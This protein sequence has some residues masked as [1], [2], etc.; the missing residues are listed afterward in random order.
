MSEPDATAAFTANF[1]D[2]ACAS[3]PAVPVNCTVA[4]AA[5]A[6]AAAV[7]LTCCDEPGAR[8]NES[9]DVAIPD[10]SPV[11]NT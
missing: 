2:A 1:T 5:G 11:T 9:G 8:V 3:P 6:D 4:A 7:K 10:G